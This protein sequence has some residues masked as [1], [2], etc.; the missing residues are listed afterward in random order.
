[1]S[2]KARPS[3]TSQRLYNLEPAKVV[4]AV[5]QRL[6]AFVHLLLFR[7]IV[8][9]AKGPIITA[10][11]LLEVSILLRKEPVCALTLLL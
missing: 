9:V 5:Q 4:D 7:A 11:T 6:N 2:S 1:M 10:A 3:S 8:V